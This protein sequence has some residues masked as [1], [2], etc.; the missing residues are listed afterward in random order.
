[1]KDILSKEIKENIAQFDKDHILSNII[2]LGFGGEIR[3]IMV[4][5]EF[6]ETYTEQE[7]NKNEKINKRTKKRNKKVKKI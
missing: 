1:M 7:L 5:F 2:L 3:N 6:D 4:G